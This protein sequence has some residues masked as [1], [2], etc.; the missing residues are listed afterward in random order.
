MIDIAGSLSGTRCSR[1]FLVR[2]AGMIHSA[3]SMSISSQ[4]AAD[5]ARPRAGQHQQAQRHPR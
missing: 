5:L 2:A 4:R 3:A 1:P